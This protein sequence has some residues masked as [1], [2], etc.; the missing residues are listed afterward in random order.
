MRTRTKKDFKENWQ[1]TVTAIL[2]LVATLLVSFGLID[3]DQSIQALPLV[4]TIITAVGGIIAA[5]TAIIGI[6]FKPSTE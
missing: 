5:V 6:F 2:A 1:Q 4:N 3:A